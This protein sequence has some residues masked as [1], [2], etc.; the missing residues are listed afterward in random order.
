MVTPFP[1]EDDADEDVVE[2]GVPLDLKTVAWLMELADA[3][4]APP[5]CVLASLI[6]GVREDDEAMHTDATSTPAPSPQLN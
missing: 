3:C 5:A 1:I 2:F 4:H 6:K